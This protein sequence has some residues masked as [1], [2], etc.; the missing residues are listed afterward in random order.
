V[1]A[2]HGEAIQRREQC[3]KFQHGLDLGLRSPADQLPRGV[4]FSPDGKWIVFLSYE[5]DVKRARSTFRRGRR[6]AAS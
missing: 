6:T 1:D 3:L 5:R 2:I 4:S